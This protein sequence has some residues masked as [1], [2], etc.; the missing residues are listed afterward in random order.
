MVASLTSIQALLDSGQNINYQEPEAG[1]TP[2][3]AAISRRDREDVASELIGRGANLELT[4]NHGTT[5]LWWACFNGRLLVV[6]E[7]LLRG[8]MMTAPGNYFQLFKLEIK[9]LLDGW[10]P[11]RALWAV[12]FAGEVRRVGKDL[13]FKFFP[14]DLARMLGK[15]L[16]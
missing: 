7:L 16:V 14:K 6:K 12:R 1:W 4:C 13:H 15:F 10:R 11:I 5:P 9:M 8:L 2:L 3:I